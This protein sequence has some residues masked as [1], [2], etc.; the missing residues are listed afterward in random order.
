MSWYS[1]EALDEELSVAATAWCE[2]NVMVEPAGVVRVSQILSWY[3]KDFLEAGVEGQEVD[4]GASTAKKRQLV[5]PLLPYVADEE[6]RAAL[7]AALGEGQ[8]IKLEFLP[9]DWS[10]DADA[11]T[12]SFTKISFKPFCF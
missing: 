1:A 8:R 10:T 6:K 3:E 7:S 5:A 12:A 2:D 11:E 9:Y 4:G